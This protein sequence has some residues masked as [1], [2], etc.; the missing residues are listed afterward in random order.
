MKINVRIVVRKASN[1]PD[2]PGLWSVYF[3][4]DTFTYCGSF[5]ADS[6]ESLR[7]EINRVADLLAADDRLQNW[8]G[9]NVAAEFLGNRAPI[10]WK[11]NRRNR[12]AFR[13][14][15]QPVPA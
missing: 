13:T 1:T 8:P 5:T 15:R 7:A 12:E 6:Y 4:P 9:L 3:G 11:D 14:I 10:R 2:A